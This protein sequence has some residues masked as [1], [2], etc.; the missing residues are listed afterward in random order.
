[1]DTHTFHDEYQFS[2]LANRL[3]EPICKRV[4]DGVTYVERS[5]LA[6]DKAGVDFY[7]HKEKGRPIGIDVKHRRIDPLKDYG[8]MDLAL[9]IWSVKDVTRGWTVDEK[10]ITDF[11]LWIFPTGRYQLMPYQQLRKVTQ[12]NEAAWLAQY[13]REQKNERYDS[14][15]VFVPTRIIWDQIHLLYSGSIL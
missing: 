3:V 8:V 13:Y 11:V 1:M 14:V 5:T 15:S 6:Q 4:F 12:R 2:E 9:E 7:V 10:K